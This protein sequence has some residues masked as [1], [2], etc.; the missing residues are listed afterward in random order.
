MSKEIFTLLQKNKRKSGRA[1]LK[2]AKTKCQWR[3]KWK[4]FKKFVNALMTLNTNIDLKLV[5]KK[6]T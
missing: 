5:T 3:K 6:K 1:S 2:N 4:N